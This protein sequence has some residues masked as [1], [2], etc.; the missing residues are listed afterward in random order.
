MAVYALFRDGGCHF[1][2]WSSK[3]LQ[4]KSILTIHS[5]S[6]LLTVIVYT[7][8]DSFE[9]LSWNFI[10]C[11]ITI[12]LKSPLLISKACEAIMLLVV[13]PLCYNAISSIC[14]PHVTT[15]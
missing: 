1:I 13:L 7:C 3:S 12:L 10:I 8:N 15:N 9:A 6:H 11:T 14:S 5:I 4:E 2:M